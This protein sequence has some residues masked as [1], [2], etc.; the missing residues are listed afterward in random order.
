MY[1]YEVIRY[2]VFSTPLLGQHLDIKTVR[3]NLF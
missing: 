2:T 1:I 3:S